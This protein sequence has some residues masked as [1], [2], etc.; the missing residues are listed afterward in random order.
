MALDPFSPGDETGTLYRRRRSFKLFGIRLGP[1]RQ[2]LYA[3]LTV[4][5]SVFANFVFLW[6]VNHFWPLVLIW[7]SLGSVM[8]SDW[9]RR[10]AAIGAGVALAGL[11]LIYAVAGPAV[12]R[13][14]IDRTWIVPMDMPTPPNMCQNVA[15]K[16]PEDAKLVLVGDSAVVVRMGRSTPILAVGG[17]KSVAMWQ[18]GAGI[19]VGVDD[20]DDY[21]QPIFRISNNQLQLIDGQPAVQER[22]RDHGSVAIHGDSDQELLRITYLNPHALRLRGVFA[23][24]GHAPV[25]IRDATPIPGVTPACLDGRGVDVP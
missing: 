8:L 6:P 4:G 17:C 7:V 23:C 24:K 15:G 14:S 18:N 13:P 1:R 2:V 16:L 10:R 22:T 11:A 19:L 5:F 20:Y 12:R 9:P 3:A 21:G 25:R